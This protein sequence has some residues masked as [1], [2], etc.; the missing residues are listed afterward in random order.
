MDC[1]R[2]FLVQTNRSLKKAKRDRKANPT[3]N[4][5]FNELKRLKIKKYY[6]D[7]Q[8]KEIYVNVTLKDGTR[9]QVGSFQ[10]TVKEKKKKIEN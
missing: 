4:T 2:S 5:I 8:L 7:P 6:E 9:K 1:F 3:R 10:V